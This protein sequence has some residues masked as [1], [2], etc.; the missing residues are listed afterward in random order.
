MTQNVSEILSAI[1]HPNRI[2]IIKELEKQHTLC[3]CEIQP[4]LNLEQSNLS[5]HLSLLVKSGV[6][7]SWKDG[8]RVNYKVK[9]S[10][11]FQIIELAEK[12]DAEKLDATVAV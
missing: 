1:S 10:R 3:A 6:L 9:D 5:R 2:R 7:I 11:I 8:V 4:K 12:I